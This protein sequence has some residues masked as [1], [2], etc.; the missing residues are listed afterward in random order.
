MCWGRGEVEE[1]EQERWK[2]QQ[3]GG[4]ETGRVEERREERREERQRGMRGEGHLLFET[5][6]FKLI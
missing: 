2:R 3:I 6:Y 4:E 5:T 1:E